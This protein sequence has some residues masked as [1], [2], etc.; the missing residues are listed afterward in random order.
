M[1]TTPSPSH[2]THFDVVIVGAGLSG[3]GAGHYLQTECPWADYAIFEARDA[4]GGTWDLFRYPGHP[5]RLR[6]AHAGLFVP[7]LGRREVDRRRG[8]HTAVHQGHRGGVRSRL[9]HP[10]PSPDHGRRLVDARFALAHH[11]GAD[12][13]ER[14]HPPHGGLSLLVQRVLPL[15]PRLPARLRRDGRLRGNDRAPTGLAGGTGLRRQA[16]RCH[17]QRSD[18][19]HPCSGAGAIG[20]TRDHAAALADVHRLAA[21]EESRRCAA[22]QGPAAETG[23]CGHEVVPCPADAG[24]LPGEPEISE[25]G[26]AHAGQGAGTTAAPRLRHRHAFHAP[27]RP[28][29]PALLR[30]AERGPLPG[31]LGRDR[32]G[33]DG[34]DRSLHRR[35]GSSSVRVPSSRRTSS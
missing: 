32:I 6:H 7:S 4:I 27:L 26:P 28:V 13:H 33:G 9:P 35:T 25:A 1:E 17:R 2:T 18:R 34:P 3:I 30:R 14:D 8:L 24:L 16:D 10:L 20:G 21:G 22:A 15:R 23:R 31:D 5:L 12:G 29:G 19:R 11:G